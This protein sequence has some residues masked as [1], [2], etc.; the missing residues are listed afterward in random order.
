MPVLSSTKVGILERYGCNNQK[1][2]SRTKQ[3]EQYFLNKSATYGEIQN[4]YFIN[5]CSFSYSI[6]VDF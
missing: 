1:V 3:D 4:P 2:I 5:H 6:L